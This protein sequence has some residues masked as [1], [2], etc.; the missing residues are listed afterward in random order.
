MSKALPASGHEPRRG[1]VDAARAAYLS[2]VVKE[3]RPCIEGCTS[4]STR[5]DGRCNPCGQRQD[6]DGDIEKLPN[7]GACT[8]DVGGMLCYPNRH[9]QHC[10]YY[11]KPVPV[12][13]SPR[14]D[15]YAAFLQERGA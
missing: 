15:K 9:V 2:E 3:M 6:A 14:V 12:V 13:V 1:V 5:P 10:R 11:K 8:P 4:R 7:R